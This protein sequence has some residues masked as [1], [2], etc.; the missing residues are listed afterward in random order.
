MKTLVTI[1]ADPMPAAP[2][3]RFLALFTVAR[4]HSAVN[5]AW[6]R[7]SEAQVLLS[8]G[9]PRRSRQAASLCIEPLWAADRLDADVVPLDARFGTLS[10]VAA[11]DRASAIALRART[12]SAVARRPDLSAMDEWLSELW[13]QG[14]LGEEAHSS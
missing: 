13:E 9:R 1:G 4:H 10:L 12:A 14:A 11:L 5:W 8:H 3:A 6:V 2:W 7:A